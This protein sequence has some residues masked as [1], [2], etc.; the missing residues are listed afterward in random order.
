M[1]SVPLR[2][3]WPRLKLVFRTLRSLIFIVF[4]FTTGILYAMVVLLL[5]WAPRDF[6]WG[7]VLGW[8]RLTLWAGD[9]FAALRLSQRDMKTCRSPPAFL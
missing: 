3:R 6:L 9:F 7:F 5:F 2:P 1:I 4:G 8:C